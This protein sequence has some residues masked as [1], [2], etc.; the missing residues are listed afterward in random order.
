MSR[1]F[2]DDVRAD[3]NAAIIPNGAG[4]ITA[5]V[6]RPILIDSIDSSIDDEAIIGSSLDVIGLAIND[7]TW[8]VIPCDDSVGGDAQFLNVDLANNQ[9]VTSPTAGYTYASSALVNLVGANN[10]RFEIAVLEDGTPSGAIGEITARGNNK[11]VNVTA[12]GLELSTPSSTSY[13]IGIRSID[14]PADT[15]DIHDR[16]LSVTIKPT[17]N[18]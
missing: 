14:D 2:L 12:F 17:N 9:I 5:D 18:P 4:L 16:A 13:T 10:K 8:T 1:R 11:P 3:I 7:T 15:L 6:L